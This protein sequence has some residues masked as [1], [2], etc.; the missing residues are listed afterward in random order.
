LVITQGKGFYCF[1]SKKGGDQIALVAHIRDLQLKDAAQWIAGRVQVPSTGNSTVPQPQGATGNE[2]KKFGPL[3]Y[4]E[5][6]HEAVTAVGFDT[7]FAKKH[8]IGYAPKGTMSGHVLIPFR[9]ETGALLG[10]VGVTD[11]KLPA[12][13]TPNVVTFKQ[14]A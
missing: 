7:D 5:P 14:R 1:R 4:L 6:E 3:L 2:T 10:Y 13:F 11:C 8:G 12:D 9:D